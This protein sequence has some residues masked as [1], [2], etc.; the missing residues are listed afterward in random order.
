ML[1]ISK[2]IAVVIIVAVTIAISIA[3]AMWLIGVANTAG[4]GT[5]PVRLDIYSFQKFGPM[6][7]LI[8][9]N[10]GSE[11]LLVDEI[12]I[13]D[14]PSTIKLV[15]DLDDPDKY[16]RLYTR[17]VNV[18]NDPIRI[19]PGQRVSVIGIPPVELKSGRLY[20]IRIKTTIGFE[21]YV[22]LEITSA[23]PVE[24]YMV[25]LVALTDTPVTRVYI[26]VDGGV[27]AWLNGRK[28]LSRLG[29]SVSSQYWNYAVRVRDVLR[30]GEN[31]LALHVKRNTQPTS[32]VDAEIRAECKEWV[33]SIPGMRGKYYLFLRLNRTWRY[34]TSTPPS[35]WYEPGFNDTGWR[36]GEAPIGNSLNYATHVSFTDLYARK[37]I[38]IPSSIG[39]VE[40]AGIA[41][42]ELRIA[43]DDG[44]AAYINGVNVLDQLNDAHG[45]DYWNYYVD[46]T[47]N[48][49]VGENTVAVHVHN[50]GGSSFF[51]AELYVT[52]A[53]RDGSTATLVYPVRAEARY[54]TGQEP[55]SDW[56]TLGFN[57]TGW[58][59]G[60]LPIGDHDG[61]RRPNTRISYD[62]IYVRVKFNITWL[63]LAL[64]DGVYRER[65]S[66]YSGWLVEFSPVTWEYRFW[67]L[68]NPD[69]DPRTTDDIVLIGENNAIGSLENPPK[70]LY[71]GESIVVQSYEGRAHQYVVDT[72]NGYG[73][74]SPFIIVLNPSVRKESNY[75][76]Y[77]LNEAVKYK[78]IREPVD[79]AI[80]GLDFIILWEDL[81]HGPPP[82]T[83]WT[84]NDS[85]SL[86][87]HVVRVTWREDGSVR[88]G[89]YRCS[90][91]YL[92]V[93][94][95]GTK[96]IYYKPHGDNW[97]E[98]TG[99]TPNPRGI[100]WYTDA[101]GFYV[102]YERGLPLHG[103]DHW[104]SP[105]GYRVQIWEI[106]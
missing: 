3:Y 2:I 20:S 103:Y 49:A 53:L 79:R 102:E 63:P 59:L 52:V 9:R 78:Y 33:P 32:Y 45:G 89:V 100:W 10:T 8:L 98:T 42:A 74:D 28:I 66:G 6:Y 14:K 94:V 85:Y 46:V 91:G 26:S 80:Q 87:D 99:G 64:V 55:P 105:T 101:D 34:T 68:Y 77:N 50:N 12:Y 83:T 25:R 18:H 65:H 27:D 4:Y 24:M 92:H 43:S 69:G 84:W 13:N 81:W 38:T 106:K 71:Q 104:I 51:D 1:A 29:D 96:Y 73:I 23:I 75:T 39:G 60:F 88:I 97:G 41:Y 56:Y 95:L 21:A 17:G 57:D 93:F 48:L 54:L 82:T 72:P 15:Y 58:N 35:N 90:G 70:P 30:E 37:T 47:N 44:A 61:N 31:V 36:L 22:P 40:V 19:D 7:R 86:I 5:R 62:E 67:R 76:W 11:S 16:F